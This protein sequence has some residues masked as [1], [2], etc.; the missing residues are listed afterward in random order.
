MF[1]FCIL[2]HDFGIYACILEL[3][4]CWDNWWEEMEKAAQTHFPKTIQA[5][6]WGISSDLSF[7]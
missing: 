5:K 1:I 6:N 2:A 3:W 4:L 7:C